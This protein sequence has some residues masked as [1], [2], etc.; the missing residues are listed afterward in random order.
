MA[1]MSIKYYNDMYLFRIY[2][3]NIKKN[4]ASL[5]EKQSCSRFHK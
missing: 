2:V 5:K 4:H 3:L 1:A